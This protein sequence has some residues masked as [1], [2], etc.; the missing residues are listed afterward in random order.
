MREFLN[1]EHSSLKSIKSAES[2]LK[3]ILA[4]ETVLSLVIKAFLSKS[5]KPNKI[6]SD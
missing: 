3:A 4:S 1:H 5:I 2:Q 6:L